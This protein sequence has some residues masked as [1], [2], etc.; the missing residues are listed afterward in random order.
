MSFYGKAVSNAALKGLSTE[1]ER[2]YADANA[3]AYRLWNL[4]HAEVIVWLY[5]TRGSPVAIAGIEADPR[6]RCEPV[7]LH[8]TGDAPGRDSGQSAGSESCAVI[9]GACCA[10]TW[11]VLSRPWHAG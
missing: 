7:C 9:L 5:C 2:K 6:Q 4:H 11:Y 3:E 10:D 1:Y 8:A